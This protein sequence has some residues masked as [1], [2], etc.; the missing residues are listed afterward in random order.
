MRARGAARAAR[1]VGRVGRSIRGTGRDAK[2]AEHSVSMFGRGLELVQTRGAALIITLG[3]LAVIAGPPLIGVLVLATAAA[4]ALG[5]ALLPIALLVAATTSRFEAMKEVAGS[6]AGQLAYVASGFK[7][8]WSQV[9]GPG[10]DILM[11]GLI[12]VMETLTPL[13]REMQGPLTFIARETARA[14]NAAAEGFAAMG[15]EL[16]QLA[17]AAGPVI[18]HMGDFFPALTSALIH[19]AIAGM[20][21]LAQLLKWLTDFSYWLGPAIDNAVEF[22]HS[23]GFLRVVGDIWHGFASV[24]EYVSAVVADL[25]VIFYGTLQQFFRVK[26]GAFIAGGALVALGKAIDFVAHN[27]DFFG[28]IL[29]AAIVAWGAYSIAAGVAAAV[30]AVAAA[31]IVAAVAAVAALAYGLYL[32]YQRWGWFRDAV[33]WTATALWNAAKAVGSFAVQLKNELVSAFNAVKGPVQWL[34]DKLKWIINASNSVTG[35][36]GGIVGAVS[37]AVSKIPG[38][39]DGTDRVTRSGAALV[40]RDEVIHLPK[41]AAVEPGGFSGGGGDTIIQWTQM[42]DGRVLAQ[43]VERAAR[44]KKSTR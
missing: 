10:A 23:A 22:A 17:R 36:A 26:D 1:D 19:L 15:P 40:H 24:V 4:V 34:Y 14:M 5:G 25:A 11:K 29:A 31:P 16:D 21:V 9:T 32:A 27:M 6:T 28:P 41:G 7:E 20:P 44:K 12:S 42:L 37:G 8:V 33:N 30:T 13:L 38:L 3:V 39:A 43:G 35:A 18:G 2:K